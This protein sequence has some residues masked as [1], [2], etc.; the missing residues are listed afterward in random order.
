MTGTFHSQDLPFY[1]SGKK[2]GNVFSKVCFSFPNNVY[3]LVKPI[4]LR[5]H[6]AGEGKDV[7]ND[8]DNI[9]KKKRK[10]GI[11][12]VARDEENPHGKHLTIYKELYSFMF[13]RR[14]LSRVSH[15]SDF[16]LVD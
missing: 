13:E 2:E 11:S 14:M 15:N 5:K 6:Q 12:C 8:C 1:A 3:I 9:G 4:W 16:D 7:V 10:K